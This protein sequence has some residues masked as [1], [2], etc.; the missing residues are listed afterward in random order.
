MKYFQVTVIAKR[1]LQFKA[2]LQWFIKNLFRYYLKTSK[3]LHLQCVK[4]KNVFIPNTLKRQQVTLSFFMERPETELSDQHEDV[5]GN[6]GWSTKGHW[7]LRKR[8]CNSLLKLPKEM[9]DAFLL[10]Q[11]Q[12]HKSIARNNQKGHFSRLVQIYT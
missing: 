2:V 3:I 12:Q 9:T 4:N 11:N 10:W 1:H 5:Q 7:D 8:E 6:K